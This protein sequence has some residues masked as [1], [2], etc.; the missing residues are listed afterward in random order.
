[1]RMSAISPLFSTGEHLKLSNS[2]KYC[3]IATSTMAKLTYFTC[4]KQLNVL[5]F[6][7]RNVFHLNNLCAKWN[8]N[9]WLQN[10]SVKGGPNEMY[11]VHQGDKA[12]AVR[13]SM[14]STQNVLMFWLFFLV[15]QNWAS[16]VG[17][18]WALETTALNR[19]LAFDRVRVEIFANIN[20][21][22]ANLR[23]G[24]MF[25]ENVVIFSCR[26]F[27][28]IIHLSISYKSHRIKFIC[29]EAN[30]FD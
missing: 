26:H 9:Y 8:G 21:F 17:V 7:E 3:F 18:W 15:R 20:S 11:S 29:R 12:K 25:V 24:L 14:H 16:V 28:F 1:M 10:I 19:L 6:F 23:L 5:W 30:L 2:R 27:A 22:Y 13:N 4:E